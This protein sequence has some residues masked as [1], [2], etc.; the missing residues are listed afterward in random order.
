VPGHVSEES[1]ILS[2]GETKRWFLSGTFAGHV[3]DFGYIGGTFSVGRYITPSSRVAFE[4]GG[5]S[6]VDPKVVGSF[7]WHYTDSSIIH[8]DGKIKY[9]HTIIPILISW[10]YQWQLSD[11]WTARVGPTL[12][13]AVVEGAEVR[14]PEV[15]NAANVLKS[16]SG[17]AFLFGASGGLRWDFYKGDTFD[18]YMDITCKI[19]GASEVKL[20]KFDNEKVKLSG[21]TFG[22]ALGVKF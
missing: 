19:L 3:S 10:E 6:E 18:W 21:A 22:L 20:E 17:T 8:Y 4:I 16:D 2:E 13:F 1:P 7:A 9:E 12:G 15:T 14:D 5:Y 11:K